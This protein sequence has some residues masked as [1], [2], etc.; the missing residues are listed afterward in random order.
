MHMEVKLAKLIL[1][2][3]NLSK[4]A[5]KKFNDTVEDINKDNLLKEGCKIH[6]LLEDFWFQKQCFKA[7]SEMTKAKQEFDK[8]ALTFKQTGL[9][10]DSEP[11]HIAIPPIKD[12]V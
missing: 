11:S 12:G 1:S 10:L 3:Q 6:D 2:D 8:D 4:F 7:E 5:F 9:P